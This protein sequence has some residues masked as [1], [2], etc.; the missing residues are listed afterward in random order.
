[1]RARAVWRIICAGSGGPEVVVGLCIERSLAMPVGLVGILKAGG[2]YLP[3]DPDYP[4]ERLAFMLADA[5]A[6][7]L[8]TRTALR[9][10][11]PAHD[12][13]SD[14]GVRIDDAHIV[15]LDADWPAIARQPTTAPITGLAPH[16]PAYVIYTS[17]STGTPKGVVVTHH[18]VVRLVKGADYVD[19]TSDDVFLHLAPL[20]FDASTFEIWGALLNGARL[21]ISPD[22]PLD[23]SN[24]KRIISQAGVSVLW[25]TAALFHQVVDED[26]AAIACVKQLLAG[27]DV[28]SVPHVRKVIEAQTGCRFINGYGPTE[29]TTFSACF[30]VTSSA[31]L[32]DSVPIGRPISN[33]R[34]YVLDGGLEP[35]PAGVGG[36]LYIAGAGLARGYVGRAGLTA[37]RF[38]A[39]PFGPAGSRMYRTG[40][41]ARWRGDGV[42][43]FLG[44]ADAQVKVR[45]FRIEPGEIEAALVCHAGV[46]QAAVIAREDGPGGKRLVGYVVPAGDAVLDA[47]ALRVHLGQSLPE[48]MVPSALVVL[49]R[50]P[51]TPNG[52]LDRRALP[53]PEHRV[54]AVRRAARTPQEEILCGLFAEVLGLE[55]VGIDDNFFAL[56]GDSIMS[57]QLVSRA[58]KA[59]LVITPRAVFQHQTIAA[60]SGVV[61]LV[62]QTPS[63]VAEIATGPLPPTPIMHWLLERGG[64]I[65]RFCQAMLLQVPAG[66]QRDHLV[67]ALQSLL[68]AHGALRL[69]LG[70]ASGAR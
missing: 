13:S 69:R 37:E 30:G 12:A 42:L 20:S 48:H 55:R 2:A 49:D 15:C 18:N 57:I 23:L 67:G 1:M 51:L 33:T 64:P 25:L 66:L 38:V 10:H 35:V 21:V 60:L 45:G 43:E 61:A 11:L 6:P 31:D 8:L 14:G 29:G 36:E 44:R 40:D 16:H 65:D 19:L 53:A 4:P 54:G 26:L 52:K 32:H 34:V 27:G 22:G 68:D 39:D 70:P 59:G 47:A 56:G 62:A 28:L 9:A 24:L 63:P 7:V 5:G 17:G 41:L 50:L 46:A 58:R 3:L